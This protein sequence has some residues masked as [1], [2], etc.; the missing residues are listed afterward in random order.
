MQYRY[1]RPDGACNSGDTVATASCDSDRDRASPPD[2]S[3]VAHLGAELEAALV[4][5][6]QRAYYAINATFFRGMLRPPAFE[7]T[8]NR[9]Y[10]GRWCSDTRTIQIGR[11]VAIG[12]PWTVVLEVLKHEMAHQHVHELLGQP[13][14]VHGP[15]FR[16]VCDQL[17]IDARASGLPRAQSLRENGAEARV[18]SRVGHLL[19]LADSPNEHE[20]QAAMKAAQRLML[21]YNIDEAAAR[22]ERREYGFRQLGRVTGRVSEWE[23]LLASLLN[24]HFF[25]QVI[26]VTAYVPQTGK[27]GSVLEVCGTEANLEM[28]AYVHSFMSHTAEQLWAAHRREHRIRSNRDR[29]TFLAGVMV[30]FHK[31]LDDE[32]A[33]QA[34][35]GL[36][37]AGDDD[38]RGYLRQRHPHIRRIRR[39]G[40]RRTDARERGKQA[41]RSIVLRKPVR[42][43]ADTG[44]KLLPSKRG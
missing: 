12:Q 24:D 1:T 14:D 16:Q 30:G 6:L 3:E 43:A 26:W 28:A 38:L 27:R 4:R 32:R 18:L 37:W 17:G 8:T 39:E 40:N 2:P 25:V 33:R 29:Q 19:A 34:G 21:R 7:L 5:E 31:R 41:G 36:V 22:S 15:A 11:S 10:L 9:S 42:A 23:R 13:D 35:E 20:A 44:G